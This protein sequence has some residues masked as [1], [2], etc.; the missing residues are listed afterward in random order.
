MNH[1]QNDQNLRIHLG[2]RPFLRVLILPQ[3]NKFMKKCV[4]KNKGQGYFYLR[5]YRQETKLFYLKWHAVIGY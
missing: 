5:H 2:G 3:L 4:G 1:H